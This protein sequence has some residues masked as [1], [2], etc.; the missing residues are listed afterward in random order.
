MIIRKVEIF[1][2]G[3]WLQ[4]TF[5]LDANLQVFSG[6]NESGK[7]SIRNL[8]GHILY[9]FPNRTNN[10]YSF[11]PKKGQTTGGRL[12]IE[13]ARYGRLILER[14]TSAGKGKLTWIQEDGQIIEQP[15]LGQLL[16]NV[17]QERFQA[18][19][20]FNWT[21]LQDFGRVSPDMVN[22]YLLSI[23]FTGSQHVVDVI[24]NFDKSA[25]HLYRSKGTK[26]P[27]NQDLKEAQLIKKRLLASKELDYRYQD[28][29]VHQH[30]LQEK[31][32]HLRQ[33]A[34]ETKT[35]LEE[36]KNLLSL[37]PI[38]QEWLVDKEQVSNQNYGSFSKELLSEF[39]RASL[40]ESQAQDRI[41][42]V[43]D[44]LQEL[45]FHL[46]LAHP[47]QWID[48]NQATI[49]HLLGKEAEIFEKEFRFIEVGKVLDQ[50][51]HEQEVQLASLGI[52]RKV[53]IPS[54]IVGD[55]RLEAQQLLQK[56][57]QIQEQLS[58]LMVQREVSLQQ[59]SSYQSRT[60]SKEVPKENKVRPASYFYVYLSVFLFLLASALPFFYPFDLGQPSFL[61]FLGGEIGLVGIA[62]FLLVTKVGKG[63]SNVSHPQDQDLLQ[64]LLTDEVA[65]Q[66]QLNREVEELQ[67]KL[68]EVK[69]NKA[70]WLSKHGYQDVKLTLQDILYQ[71]PFETY[72]RL[73]EKEKALE[74]E[75]AGLSQVLDTYRQE[76]AFFKQYR[77][78]KSRDSLVDE[79]RALKHFVQESQGAQLQKQS[80]LDKKVE[81]ERDLSDL[82][83]TIQTAQAKKEAILEASGTSSQED[84][85]HLSEQREKQ[86]QVA[87]KISHYW[88]LIEPYQEQLANFSAKAEIEGQV[89][90]LEMTIQE[91]QLVEEQLNEEW[92]KVEQ[93]IRFLE[94]SGSY[95][96]LLQEYEAKVEMTRRQMV[97]WAAYKMASNILQ[98]TLTQGKE[99]QFQQVLEQASNYFSRLTFG[100]FKSIHLSEQQQFVEASDGD[101]FQFNQLS[102]GTLDQL[103]VS[104]RLAFIKHLALKAPLPLVVD[105]G[106]VNFDDKRK[107]LMM[108]ILQEISQDTQVIY[109][110]LDSHMD[111][112]FPR[113]QLT[114]L[115]NHR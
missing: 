81:L 37:Y 84:F 106:F 71:D 45:D 18:I 114:L 32:T 47:D 113:Q 12:Y 94:E 66:V 98:R 63:R 70:A 7:S 19:Y 62:I 56:E 75:V 28:L 73:Q 53:I 17:N 112:L 9:G 97:D 14:T 59:V 8:I 83:K 92:A 20:S 44:K 72:R 67:A 93:E 4:E 61:Y 102:Q 34:Q 52:S 46:Q 33:Q 90:D 15:D 88:K 23:G 60:N 49:K 54:T 11:T 105:D 51:E 21:Q 43:Q 5:E 50:L 36:T 74:A 95:H 57:S 107:N 111:H 85:Y 1:G 68:E 65:Q 41:D 35:T 6:P 108:E 38:Y 109:F 27:L 42:Q 76:I 13:D 104:M 110:T 69:Q 25:N 89:T 86:E 29:K 82:K 64:T 78:E 101:Y 96:E 91:E 22:E 55:A 103:Y 10:E 79:W 87:A 115:N 26:Y 16:Y 58:K 31:R 80:S 77:N 3:K 48:D 2:Y 39:E 40:I 99:G 24:K 30:Q 100:A